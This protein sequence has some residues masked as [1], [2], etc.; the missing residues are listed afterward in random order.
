MYLDARISSIQG[1]IVESSVEERLMALSLH[2]FVSSRVDY[3]C[4]RQRSTYPTSG[5]FVVCSWGVTQ[6]MDLDVV[7]FSGLRCINVKR[8]VVKA[9]PE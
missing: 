7:H 3:G 5:A 6:C 1:M 4:S 9:R 8:R 2:V